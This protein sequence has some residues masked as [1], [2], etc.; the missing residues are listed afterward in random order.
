MKVLTHAQMSQAG[1]KF[2]TLCTA[3]NYAHKHIHFF[4]LRVWCAWSSFPRSWQEA[5]WVEVPA[6]SLYIHFHYAEGVDLSHLSNL[7]SSLVEIVYKLKMYSTYIH[8]C[9]PYS[10]SPFH[11]AHA[12]LY[13]KHLYRCVR[14]TTTIMVKFN[15]P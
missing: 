3:G 1:Y 13:I 7:T 4:T 14:L 2:D 8:V 15:I 10:L 11:G 9:T 6:S 5:K 12:V